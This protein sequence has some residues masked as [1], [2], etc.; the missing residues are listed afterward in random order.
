MS[1]S[2][3]L[4]MPSHQ[5]SNWTQIRND[6][7]SFTQFPSVQSSP[8]FWLL[9]ESGLLNGDFRFQDDGTTFA[10]ALEERPSIFLWF[11]FQATAVPFIAARIYNV[12]FLSK[13]G[14][15]KSSRFVAWTGK[16][17][18]SFSIWKWR[19]RSNICRFAVHV[20]GGRIAFTSIPSRDEVN[21]N[22]IA[23]RH[24]E[25]TTMVFHFF[26]NSLPQ[27][28][29]S[30]ARRCPKQRKEEQV[31]MTSLS[32]RRQHVLM[33]SRL[34]CQCTQRL[35]LKVFCRTNHQ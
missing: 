23:Q 17:A 1:P 6:V 35:P 21:A 28:G 8:P 11:E 4:T 22:I 14:Y 31:N 2:L 9:G 25:P 24:D 12:F 34:A 10:N 29:R 13:L 27:S 33:G 19:T 3:A 30:Y 15:S 20:G 18:T 26:H 7:S 16:K 32:F 5:S